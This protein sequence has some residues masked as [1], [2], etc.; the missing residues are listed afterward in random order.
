M[1]APEPYRQPTLRSEQAGEWCARIAEDSLT[2]VETAAFEAWLTADPLNRKAFDDAVLIWQMMDNE[3]ASA[4]LLETRVDALQSMQPKI[5]A[6]RTTWRVSGGAAAAVALIVL[7]LNAML[8][9]HTSPDVYETGVGERR[10]VVL[11]DGSRLS[12]DGA[13]RLEVAY[14]GDRRLLTLSTGRAKFDVESDPLRPFS[15]AAGET[16][17]VATGTSFSVEL[18]HEQMRLVLYEGGVAVLSGEQAPT[19]G[20]EARGL[21]RLAQDRLSPSHELVVSARNPTRPI[22]RSIDPRRSLAWE[23]GQLSFDD[24]GLATVVERI[25]RHS[26]TKLRIG[27]ATA[28]NVK[29]SGVFHAGDTDAFIQGVT[30]I[31]PLDVKRRN[32]E[33]IFVGRA[34]AQNPTSNVPQS[35]S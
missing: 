5:A 24:E 15:V 21:V 22:V 12:M 35:S 4:A 7:L 18:V 19:P 13:T 29:I 25:N 14:S 28:A 1:S 34:P 30:R 31:F 26:H 10:V 16:T 32:E 8:F 33:L 20:S 3:T 6:A 11:S 17:V 27:D 2:L 23:A 9:L